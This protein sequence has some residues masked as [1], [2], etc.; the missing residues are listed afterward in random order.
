MENIIEII[1]EKRV[2]NAKI[3]VSLKRTFERGKK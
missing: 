3:Q 1:N 2:N